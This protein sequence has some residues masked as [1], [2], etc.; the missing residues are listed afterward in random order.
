VSSVLNQKEVGQAGRQ[1][2]NT[3]AKAS[4]ALK[5]LSD[6]LASFKP[7]SKNLGPACTS[8]PEQH[9]NRKE[10]ERTRQLRDKRRPALYAQLDDPFVY[11]SDRSIKP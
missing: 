6:S 11:I 10:N 3:E 7:L 8:K 5:F 2:T 1:S 4:L 9:E